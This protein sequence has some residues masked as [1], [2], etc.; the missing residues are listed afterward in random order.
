M[1][2]IEASK[3]KRL[4]QCYNAITFATSSYM[5]MFR[6]SLAHHRGE[7]QVLQS[8]RPVHWCLDIERPETFRME[9]IIIIIIII[10]ITIGSTALGGPWPPQA[11]VASDLYLWQPPG[12]FYH[13]FSLRLP[14]HRQSV[15]ISVGHV[16]IH[17]QG[18]STIYFQVIHFHPFAQNGPSTSVYWIYYVNYIW[19][20]VKLF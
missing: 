10:I 11:N 7:L 8:D 16:L 20:I 17:F 3:R 4:Y 5:Y 13:T 18:L 12:N 6:T 14:L 1:I 9:H 19:F 2:T 15:L